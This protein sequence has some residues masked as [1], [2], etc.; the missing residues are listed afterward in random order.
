MAICPPLALFFLAGMI[1]VLSR[2]RDKLSMLVWCVPTAIAVLCAAVNLGLCTAW[3]LPGGFTKASA[4]TAWQTPAN[5]FDFAVLSSSRRFEMGSDLRYEAGLT[6][7]AHAPFTVHWSLLR[8]GVSILES[9][10]R[11][12]QVPLT[13]PGEYLAEARVKI[14]DGERVLVLFK[15]FY[16]RPTVL[17]FGEH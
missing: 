6:I 13:E 3:L 1:R 11:L 14:P 10:G 2:L 5:G 4:G 9:E 17:P 7:R 16:I 12:L 15:P 8:D